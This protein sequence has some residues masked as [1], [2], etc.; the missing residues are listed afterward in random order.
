MRN[1][2]EI[3]E[4]KQELIATHGRAQFDELGFCYSCGSFGFEDC[5]PDCADHKIFL[6]QVAEGQLTKS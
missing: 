1:Q 2:Q 5:H 3:Y 6:Q 4:R